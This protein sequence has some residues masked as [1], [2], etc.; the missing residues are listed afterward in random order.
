M[1]LS[2]RHE[3]FAQ[4][5]ASGE[6]AAAAYRAVYTK[7]SVSSAQTLGP[8]MLRNPQISFRV[9]ELRREVR[10]VAAKNF[11]MTKV[12]M[13]NWLKSI[14]DT[15]VGEVHEAHELAQEVTY[16]ESSMGSSKKV[17]MPGKLEAAEKIIRMMGWNEPDQLAVDYG[18]S[19]EAQQQLDSIFGKKRF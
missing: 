13:L 10:A 7:A 17:K 11:A 14:I 4:Q 5:V 3:A 2:T 12:T 15:P 1:N 8:E 16:C 6:S 19:P 9:N 18:L